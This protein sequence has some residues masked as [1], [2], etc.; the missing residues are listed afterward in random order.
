MEQSRVE[1]SHFAERA[2]ADGLAGPPGNWRDERGTV[3]D[4][5]LRDGDEKRGINGDGEHGYGARA[6][7][8]MQEE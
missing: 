7:R 8:E 5:I 4:I 6:T 3:Y 2:D 1:G